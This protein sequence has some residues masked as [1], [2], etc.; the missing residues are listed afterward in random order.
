MAQVIRFPTRYQPPTAR[1]ESAE[2]LILPVVRIE[3]T[4]D[5]VIF[6]DRSRRR[7]QIDIHVNGQPVGQCDAPD[8]GGDVA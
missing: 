8:T 7:R 4:P 6:R 2:V 3:R 1:A 5:A